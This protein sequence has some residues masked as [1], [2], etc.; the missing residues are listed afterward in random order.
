MIYT[1]YAVTVK[2]QNSRI[3]KYFRDVFYFIFCDRFE[4]PTFISKENF[5]CRAKFVNMSSSLTTEEYAMTK[6]C[7]LIQLLG[8]HRLPVIIFS[9]FS[10][11]KISIIVLIK[12]ILNFLI[13]KTSKFPQASPCHIILYKFGQKK[14]KKKQTNEKTTQ[15]RTKIGGKR[16]TMKK[17]C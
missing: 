7:S 13:F 16:K 8:K 9:T 4:V 1:G 14:Q 11:R 17:N 3:S 6:V 10:Y 2:Q 5:A 15:S 12:L